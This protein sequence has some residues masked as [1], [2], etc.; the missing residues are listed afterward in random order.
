MYIH[1]Y[2]DLA[3]SRVTAMELRLFSH[4]KLRSN[5]KEEQPALGPPW[6]TSNALLQRREISCDKIQVR[7]EHCSRDLN[8][9]IHVD[10]TKNA[11][12]LGQ[13]TDTANGNV[14]PRRVEYAA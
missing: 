10:E 12:T 13:T 11:E 6:N 14:T 2:T 4:R 7:L 8:F 3:H 1:T 5:R 9:S